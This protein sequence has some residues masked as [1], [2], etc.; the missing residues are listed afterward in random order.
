M[1]AQGTASID[2]GAIGAQSNEA[3]LDITGQA[4]ILSGSLVEAWVRLEATAEHSA[5]EHRVEELE[6]RAGNIVAGTGFT[7]YLRCRN[8][9]L[10]GNWTIAWVWN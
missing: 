2:A 9:P 5:D 3:T 10:Y 7:I 1:G 6:V 4:G 8:G